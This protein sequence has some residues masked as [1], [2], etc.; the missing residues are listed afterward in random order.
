[1]KKFKIYSDQLTE[2]QLFRCILKGSA[3]AQKCKIKKFYTHNGEPKN[4]EEELIK[5][6]HESRKTEYK[7]HTFYVVWGGHGL[8]ND[9]VCIFY[10]NRV[11]SFDAYYSDCPILKEILRKRKKK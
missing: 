1:M 5:D 10:K 6:I 8:H 4:W 7:G 2:K 11:Y 9:V 3:F